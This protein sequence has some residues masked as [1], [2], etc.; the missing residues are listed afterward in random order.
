MLK[1]L[2]DYPVKIIMVTRSDLILRDIDILKDL[3]VVVSFTLTTLDKSLSKKLEPNAPLP[4]KRL[5]AINE[6]SKDLPVVVRFDPLIYPLNTDEIEPMA[7]E[8]KANGARQVITSTY[9]AKPDNFKRMCNAFKE[10]KSLWEKL[11]NDQGEKKGR[12]TY[13]PKNLRK[14]LI[15]KVKTACLDEGLEFSSCREGFQKLNT[16]NCDGSSFI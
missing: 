10:H 6:L 12:Y 2:K 16:L 14:S 7:K 1:V 5:K 9:K 11:Y 3:K 8:L 15:E 4:E 13:L